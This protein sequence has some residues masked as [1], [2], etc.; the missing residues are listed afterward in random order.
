MNDEQITY[1]VFWD[2]SLLH[3]YLYGTTIRHTK[4]GIEL[5]NSMMPSGQ[6]I[7]SWDSEINY[8]ETR[9]QAMLPVLE[10]G[11]TYHLIPFIEANPAHTIAVQISFY[12][13]H[14]RLIGFQIIHSDGVFTYPENTYRYHLD[15]V[16]AGSESFLFH[17]LEICPEK[18]EEIPVFYNK[19]VLNKNIHVFLPELSHT[20]MIRM[21]DPDRLPFLENLVLAPTTLSVPEPFFKD[22]FISKLL[23][24]DE[25]LIFV[26]TGED[27][28]Q[29]AKWLQILHPGSSILEA[30]SLSALLDQKYEIKKS[31]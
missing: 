23:K 29:A 28:L 31:K 5:V 24:Q 3:T 22:N 4:G 30:R 19:E 2:S 1:L 14:D 11:K 13:R 9:S 17:H 8:Q 27:S 18:V 12:D 6:I 15:L 7:H 21:P 20:R 10:E 26:S 16:Q 25:E